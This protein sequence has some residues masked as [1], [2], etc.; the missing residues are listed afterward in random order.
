MTA[1]PATRSD[2]AGIRW[3]LSCENLPTEDLNEASADIFLVVRDAAGVIGAVA[4]EPH[5]DSMLLRSLVVA[6]D[7]RSRGLGSL[8][9]EAAQ[10]S[11]ASRGASRIFLL[12]TSAAEFFAARG[13]RILS[14]DQVPDAIR[15]T[16]QFASLCP[17]TAAVMVK[18]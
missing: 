1:Q 7:H 11:A 15:R 2:L 5:G 18:P 8:L 6:S 14:R 10:L 4:L 9:V 12:T 13:F 3:L 17:S 16:T